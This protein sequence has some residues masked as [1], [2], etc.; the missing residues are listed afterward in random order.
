MTREGWGADLWPIHRKTKTAKGH[1]ADGQTWYLRE[2]SKNKG[3]LIVC[4]L[5]VSVPRKRNDP[6]GLDAKRKQE[7]RG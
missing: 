6:P 2:K 3:G 1:Q 7:E 5:T 4:I